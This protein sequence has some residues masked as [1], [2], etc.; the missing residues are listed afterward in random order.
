MLEGRQDLALFLD[1]RKRA[2]E[3]KPLRH[4]HRDIPPPGSQWNTEANYLGKL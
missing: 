4:G 2:V 3:D 1:E